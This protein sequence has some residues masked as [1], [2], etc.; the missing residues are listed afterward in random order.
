MGEHV[1]R[2]MQS[3][4]NSPHALVGDL[5]ALRRA[6]YSHQEWAAVEEKAAA[7][8]WVPPVDASCLSLLHRHGY[9]DAFRQVRAVST[10]PDAPLPS[11]SPGISV[12][13]T[14]HVGAPMYRIDYVF[15]SQTVVQSGLL[16]SSV[17]VESEASGSDH[18]PLVVDLTYGP[19]LRA[20]L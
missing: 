3:V 7:N 18:F 10:E 12:K 14:A 9:T 5:N 20:A 13:F 15:L 19:G 8:G 16:L 4:G 17:H 2:E 1:L 6:D 11:H